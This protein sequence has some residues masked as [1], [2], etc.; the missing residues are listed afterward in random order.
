MNDTSLIKVGIEKDTGSDSQ[1]SVDNI[2]Y[3]NLDKL[4]KRR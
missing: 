1:P 3:D 4:T 2:K